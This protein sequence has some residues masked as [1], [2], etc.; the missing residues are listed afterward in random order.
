MKTTSRQLEYEKLQ[1][2]EENGYERKRNR[3]LRR[4]LKRS[5]QQSGRFK[6]Y[7]VIRQR[8]FY[9]ALRHYADDDY[10]EHGTDGA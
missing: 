9:A 2:E 5:F 8:V 10:G 3:Y 4:G 7:G 6:R 1:N